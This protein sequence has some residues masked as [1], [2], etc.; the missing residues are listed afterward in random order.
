MS[1]YGLVGLSLGT[2]NSN[3]SLSG[4]FSA[5]GK[6]CVTLAALMGKHRGLPQVSDPIIDFDFYFLKDVLVA[7]YLPGSAVG[8]NDY[9]DSV[10]RND[11][12]LKS[13]IR[14]NNNNNDLFGRGS[15]VTADS[16]AVSG[17]G[18]L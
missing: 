6:V 2:P 17:S 9:S 13:L 15:M 1:A 4:N 16:G 8:G 12:L 11:D 7:N 5:G 10:L 3:V 14:D 18:T